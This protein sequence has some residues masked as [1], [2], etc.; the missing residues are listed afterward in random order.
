MESFTEGSIKTKEDFISYVNSNILSFNLGK[1]FNSGVKKHEKIKTNEKQ[2]TAQAPKNITI[3]K[4]QMFNN[5]VAESCINYES[6]EFKIGKAG[7]VYE[8]I[9][10]YA[11]M[12]KEYFLAIYLDGAN[13]I[14]SFEIVSIGSINMCLVHPREVFA[15]A[16][17]GRAASVIIAHNHPSGDLIPSSADIDLTK[18]LLKAGE[19]LG[20]KLLDHII[21]SKNGFLSLRDD[22]DD[23]F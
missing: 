19:I 16:I 17:E 1:W 11:T 20:I 14:I 23:I 9:K 15:P 2:T 7:D 10:H 3:P 13:H 4:V 22:R 8:K 6:K 18:K 21:M 12:N 5:Y